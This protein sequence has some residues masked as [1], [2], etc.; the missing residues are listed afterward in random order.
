M[1]AHAADSGQHPDGGKAVFIMNIGI[2]GGTFNPIHL[3]HLRIAEEARE[4]FSLDR[5]LVIP[6]AQPPHKLLPGE[7]TFAARY[8]M[9]RLGV[10]GNPFFQASDLEAKRGGTSYSI[11]TLR[12]LG[13]RH[14]D[15]TLYFIM[16]SDSFADIGTW[17]Q[18]EAIFSCADI[19]VVGRPGSESF[20]L[21]EGL[22]VAMG[23]DF[24]YDP[25]ARRFSHR[26]GHF[27]HYLEGTPLDI[28]SSGIRELARHGRSLRYLVP[29]KVAG[30]IKEQ[31]LY[32]NEK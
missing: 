19:I 21:P 10:E 15:D 7:A 28:S 1:A 8:E 26:S 22:R 24:C 20:R 16:G 31:H 5:V 17:H 18:Y 4:E 23:D 6:A 3:A 14:P 11:E 32:G 29:E 30:Y 25:A 9:V 12:E 13:A 27:V 2:L